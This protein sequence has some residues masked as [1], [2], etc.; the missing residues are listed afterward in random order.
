MTKPMRILNYIL[1]VFLLF[2][3]SFSQYYF[4]KN[5]VQYRDFDFKTIETEHFRIY[6]YSGG[7]HLVE[8]FS[9]IGE[10]YYEKIS[11]EL[12]VTIEGK[13][14]VIIYNSTNEFGQTNIILDII[15]ESVGGFSEL[16]KNRV[17]LPFT[18]SY[19]EFRHVLVHELTHIFEFEMFFKPRLASVLS[20]IPD[21]Q[22]PLWVAEGLA[23]FISTTRELSSDVFMRD[24]VI[25]ERVVP[26]D[27]LTD[28]Y[29]YLVYREGE[30][31][32]RFIEERYGRKKV[33]EFL[34]SLKLKRNVMSA[35]E[36]SFGTTDQQFSQKWEEYLKI[37]YWPQIVNQKNFSEIAK[38]LTNHREDGSTYNTSV[39]ISPTG[40]KIAFI[41][42]RSEYTDVY[43]ASAI[44]GRILRRLV[45]GERSAG[46]E[47]VHL[48]RGGIAW[49]SDEKFIVF[50][51]KSGGKDGIVICEYPSGKI[52][53]RL[54]FDLD[55]VYSPSLSRDN[56]RITFVGVKN[57]FSDIYVTE[58]K[59]G[60]L[61][62]ITYDIYEDRDPSF[63]PGGDTIVFVS[64]RPTDTTWEP[65]SFAIFLRTPIKE[66]EP[67]TG[68]L[69]YY[70][71]PIFTPDGKNLIF[72]AGDSSYNIYIYSLAEQKITN[73]TQFLGGVYYPS[74]SADGEKL[75]FSYY[76][77]LG[78]DIAIIREPQN[79]IPSSE[80]P[81]TLATETKSAY[82]SEG[83][84]YAKVKP[85]Q[86]NLSLD[87][88]VGAASYSTYGGVAGTAA[89]AF[90]DA[91]GNHRFYIYTDLYRSLSNSEFF[92][93]YW[94]LPKRI[95]WGF[96]LFQYFDYPEIHSR[97]V[98]L[99]RKRG[100]QV[101][102][103]YPFN[104]FFRLETGVM[105]M[106]WQNEIWRYA[107]TPIDR[108]WYLDETYSEKVF[109]LDGALVFDNTY[110]LWTG[111]IRGTRA[112]VEVYG[113]FLS[114]RKFQTGYFDY[115]N[116]Y[117]IARRY[118]L[119]VRLVGIG[120]F[121][122]DA[123]RFYLGGEYV[124]GYK[125]A[126]FYEEKGTKLGLFNLELRHPLI[127]R[128]KIAFPIPIELSDIRG[129]TFFD[130][131]MTFLDTIR[132]WDSDKRQLKDL[133]LGIG[134][135]IRFYLS[136]F[137]LKFDWGWPLSV[138]SREDPKRRLT[139]YFGIGSD[140]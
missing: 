118:T 120:S 125:Y 21:F 2:G 104:K 25:N 1:L 39:A 59:S 3:L 136:Y 47:S 45:K 35:F 102:A 63:S 131:G 57:G 91:L 127:D 83:I 27:Q 88:A 94:L 80:L 28:D 19:S 95:D 100:L 12:S 9:K 79:K 135:G 126:E 84:D 36:A 114:D 42:D 6:F 87:Y 124:R 109:L 133:K 22:I 61:E 130:A 70:A 24:L 139:F 73:R 31:I 111:P 49:S 82:Q 99:Q 50:V 105:P 137:Q 53:K 85:Y 37:K 60:K 106:L 78:W 16:F 81:E 4:G 121:G 62:K 48:F 65:G 30:S 69:E 140:F 55:G 44:D 128:L 107:E 14:P 110:W 119:A 33:I 93:S 103:A 68:R 90:S 101:L 98:H 129:V 77:N 32:F 5:K 89:L 38:L 112:R 10:E 46:F 15:E 43:V 116:Y 76:S 40:T 134:A 58:I 51:A 11:D 92:V 56:K 54:V 7:E 52:K 18:G 13:I 20:L 64:D 75:A 115:R 74:L 117:K 72:T 26:I 41:S 8:F 71:Y 123:E 138:L 66:Y 122:R 23:E 97:L 96:A 29:G 67:L 17:V 108:Y 34:H 86:F 132:I 113:T